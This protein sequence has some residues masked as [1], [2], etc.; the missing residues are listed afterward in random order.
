[1][2]NWLAAN[3]DQPWWPRAVNGLVDNLS[4]TGRE[5]Q[6]PSFLQQFSPDMQEAI[7]ADRRKPKAVQNGPAR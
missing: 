4:D 5:D 6:I 2:M 7:Q 3:T 1:M